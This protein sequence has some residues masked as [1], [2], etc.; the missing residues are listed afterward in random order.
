[1]KRLILFHTFLFL[2]G[3][4]AYAGKTMSPSVDAASGVSITVDSWLDACPSSGMI[5][6]KVRIHNGDNQ[7]HTWSFSVGSNFGMGGGMNT[8]M[9]MTVEGGRTA[10]AMIYAAVNLQKNAGYYY[11]NVN[12]KIKGYAV[13]NEFFGALNISSSGRGTRTEY[14]GMGKKL[15]ARGW[16]SLKDKFENAKSGSSGTDLNGTELDMTEAPED[17]RGY[18]SLAQ[19]WMDGSEW[20]AMNEAGKS[21][22]LDWVALGGR[23]FILIQE[24][25]ESSL[26]LPAADSGVSRHGVGEIIKVKWDGKSFPTASVAE[27]VKKGDGYSLQKQLSRYDNKWPSRQTVGELKLNTALIFGFI[28]IFGALVGPVNL[29]WLAGVGRRQRLFWTTPLI[30]LAGSTTLIALMMLQDGLG[31]DGSRTVLAMF[32]PSQKKM[33]VMQEQ[34]SKTGVLLGRGFSKEEPSWMQPLDWRDNSKGYY[35]PSDDSRHSFTESPSFRSGDWFS[36]RAIQGQMIQAVRPSRASIEVQASTD[37]NVA[38]NVLSSIETPLQKVFIK[39]D[40]GKFWMAEDVG[41]GEKKLM[42]AASSQEFSTWFNELV[43]KSSGP[44]IST[45]VMRLRDQSGYAFA[46]G[47]NASKMAVKSLPAIR[48]NQE[49]VIFAGPYVKQP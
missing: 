36:S 34:I 6:L 48:W 49:R 26:K 25:D 5:P 46:E 32:M 45:A 40:A 3:T 11:D 19:L 15:S 21:A 22:L 43:T 24:M 44:V 9:D 39:D 42:K 29:F 28:V 10:E 38:P 18:T 23:V 2:M 17:W 33:L 16:S 35:N 12:F 1:M 41:T 4:T 20:V 14:I 37:P 7:S 27:H 31:G 30:S 13:S 47:G 8:T